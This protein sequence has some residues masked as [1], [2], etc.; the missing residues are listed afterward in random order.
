MQAFRSVEKPIS[1]TL[2]ELTMIASAHAGKRAASRTRRTIQPGISGTA[3]D[4]RNPVYL[5]SI[6]SVISRARSRDI[7]VV[8]T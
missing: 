5:K 1:S 2:E 4:V 3:P 7:D 8:S 6:A